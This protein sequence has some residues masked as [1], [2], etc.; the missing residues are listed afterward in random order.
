MS[1]ASEVR[2]WAPLVGFFGGLL[3]MLIVAPIYGSVTYRKMI[4]LVN[5]EATKPEEHVPTYAVG[6][7][8]KSF[9]VYER[10]QQMFPTDPLGKQVTTGWVILGSGFALSI[11]SIIVLQAFY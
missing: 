9:G 7:L 5:E 2:E 11:G 10:Y 6:P 1:L 8:G 4:R 3:I